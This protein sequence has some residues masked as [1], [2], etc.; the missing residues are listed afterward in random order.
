[1]TANV[2]FL[3]RLLEAR[4]LLRKTPISMTTR[5]TNQ[6]QTH[7]IVF[8]AVDSA[9][10]VVESFSPQ[11]PSARTANEAVGVIEITH[12]LACLSRASHLLLA[13]VADPKVLAL[14]LVL[15][16]LFLELSS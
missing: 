16:H 7:Q 15:L 8:L 3:G 12:S 10:N 14:F 1:M 6:C 13:C 9:V 2:A 4:I 11:R 5:R